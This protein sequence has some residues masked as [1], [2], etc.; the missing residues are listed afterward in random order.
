MVK[1][2]LRIG[3]MSVIFLA[4]L[5][6]LIALKPDSKVLDVV[7]YAW[8]GLGASLGPVIIFS[9]YYKK[10]SEIAAFIGIFIGSST[11]VIWDMLNGSIFELYS[12]VPAFLLSSLS[13]IAA[14]G[15]Y[16]NKD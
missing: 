13:I 12:L 15:F 2:K 10:M 3:R 6:T 7:S 5:A 16:P 9:L 8:A 14:S 1:E 4:F 11:V